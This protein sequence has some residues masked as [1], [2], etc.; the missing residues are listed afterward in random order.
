MVIKNKRFLPVFI[1]GLYALANAGCGVYTMRDISIPPEVKTIK[2]NFIENRASYVNPQLSPRLTN[3]LQEKVVN[4][5]RLNR[6]NEDDADWVVSGYINEYRVTTSGISNQQASL[7]RLSVG[8]KITLK[9]NLTQKTT[10]YDVIRNFEFAATQSL[11]QAEQA[12]AED[13]LKGLSEEIFNRLF[14]NW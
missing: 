12:L 10:N 4:Q 3:R 2:I 9:D 14:S 11:Q 5:T 7:N 1:M 8:A 13:I 6:T